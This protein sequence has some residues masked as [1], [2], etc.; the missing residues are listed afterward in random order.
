MTER[1][2]GARFPRTFHEGSPLRDPNGRAS[3]GRRGPL[4]ETAALRYRECGRTIAVTS[5]APIVGHG[6][7]F[8]ENRPVPPQCQP[9][10]AAKLQQT[11]LPLIARKSRQTNTGGGNRT[12][13][14]VPAQGILSPQRLPSAWRL[15]HDGLTLKSPRKTDVLASDRRQSRCTRIG[16]TWPILLPNCWQI[17]SPNTLYPRGPAT[18]RNAS[19]CR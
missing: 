16:L 18:S 7:W 4:F 1:R 17:K 19:E 3:P 9:R 6:A 2:T 13:T 12:H 8:T 5:I 14:G 10:R 15:R 11:Q